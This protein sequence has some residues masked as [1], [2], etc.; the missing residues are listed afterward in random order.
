VSIRC[1]LALAAIEEME[2][3]KMDIKI[4]FFNGD[5]KEDI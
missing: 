1:I 5:L 2:I 3:H 4:A